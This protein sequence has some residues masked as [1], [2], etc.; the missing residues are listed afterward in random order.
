MWQTLKLVLVLTFL[1][2]LIVIT[3]PSY[4]LEDSRFQRIRQSPMKTLA[5][6]VFKLKRAIGEFSAL[7]ALYS[8]AN[9]THIVP[10]W[11]SLFAPDVQH[12]YFIITV[13][14]IDSL[15]QMSKKILFKTYS[16]SLK[17]PDHTTEDLESLSQFSTTAA[18]F[19][20]TH[21]R[22]THGLRRRKQGQNFVY[23][24]RWGKYVCKY[25]N[26]VGCEIQIRSACITSTLTKHRSISCDEKV[27]RTWRAQTL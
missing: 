1:G 19:R 8:V 26:S 10:S 7:R 11:A 17:D 23:P 18:K 3:I 24:I 14:G 25:H 6:E 12:S 21:W 16:K 4:L 27:W 15:N 20:T 9:Q 22:L 5:I 13:S 2:I